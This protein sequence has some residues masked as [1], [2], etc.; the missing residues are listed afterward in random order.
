MA[1]KKANSVDEPLVKKR[2]RA[3]IMRKK[4]LLADTAGDEQ[5]L[6]NELMQIKHLYDTTIGV[7]YLKID[8]L[9][10]SIFA[11]R[12]LG[13]LLDK[14]MTLKEAQK[15]LAGRAEA[16]QTKRDEEDSRMH[17]EYDRMMRR[18]AATPANGLE[19]KK[20]WRKLAFRF[21]PDLVQDDGEKKE[22]E[23][24]M[25]KVNDAYARGDLIGLR[26]LEESDDGE[27]L[28]VDSS[29]EDLEQTLLDIES[30]LKRSKQKIVALKRS[31]W[32]SWK[33][34]L[35]AA[36]DEENDLF[37]DLEKKLKYQA[38]L[39]EKSIIELKKKL[40]I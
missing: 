1:K 27:E 13:D 31:E 25:Q 40:G 21:H 15:I 34:K 30:S 17:E 24:M 29:M 5:T 8:E 10:E 32:F 28:D 35:A 38:A 39:R 18:S 3:V 23:Q 12:K 14:D 9:D 37:K 2:I 26:L 11:L 7:L 6:R 20:L 33:E 36:I 19:L 4:K 22:R 16:E